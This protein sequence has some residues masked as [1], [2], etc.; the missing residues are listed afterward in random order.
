MDS[1]VIMGLIIIFGVLLFA[2]ILVIKVITCIV[3]WCI[4]YQLASPEKK[5]EMIRK[6]NQNLVEKNLR[7]A[8]WEAKYAITQAK[9]KARREKIDKWIASNQP[10]PNQRK[11]IFKYAFASVIMGGLSASMRRSSRKRDYKC[12][13]YNRW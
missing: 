6:Q 13:G 12:R 4:I 8:E 9:R 10:K 11:G 5:A 1:Q 7:Q 2:L 3:R